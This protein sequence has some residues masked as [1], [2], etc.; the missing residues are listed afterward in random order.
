LLLCGPFQTP[1]IETEPDP[2]AKQKGRD[3]LEG[4]GPKTIEA[5]P[6]KRQLRWFRYASS[7]LPT[8]AATTSKESFGLDDSYAREA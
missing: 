1:L 8:S 7:G 6:A 5:A 4:S 2:L 3:L